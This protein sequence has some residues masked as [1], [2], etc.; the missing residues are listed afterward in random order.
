M[1]NMLINTTNTPM[2]TNFLK[3]MKPYMHLVTIEKP[4]LD[5]QQNT[6]VLVFSI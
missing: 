3:L 6:R 2:L 5:H 1:I 4:Y